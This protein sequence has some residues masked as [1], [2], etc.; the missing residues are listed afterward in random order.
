MVLARLCSSGSS[1]G[2]FA[3]MQRDT[4]LVA[5]AKRRNAA[6]ALLISSSRTSLAMRLMLA[7]DAEEEEEE[8]HH[9][10]SGR[11]RLMSSRFKLDDMGEDRC[12]KLFRFRREDVGIIASMLQW[13]SEVSCSDGTLVTPRRRYAF[14]KE[15]GL[16]ILFGRLAMPQRWREMESIMF[17]SSGALCELFYITLNA[18]CEQFSSKVGG[19][20]SDLFV[21]SL[22]VNLT[23]LVFLYSLVS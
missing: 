7:E 23:F 13:P 15:K 2:R 6:V 19:A 4:R 1:P 8:L 21:Y 10:H 14:F 17:R 3:A 11:S 18:F 16:C 12:V 9:M 20:R 22:V 5:V